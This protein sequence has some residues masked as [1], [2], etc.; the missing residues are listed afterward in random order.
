MASAKLTSEAN[1]RDYL[2]LSESPSFLNIDLGDGT[3]IARDS[4]WGWAART[5]D[6]LVDLN[7]T[8]SSDN[9]SGRIERLLSDVR[10][11]RNSASPVAAIL[12]QTRLPRF[13]A[14]GRPALAGRVP[15]FGGRGSGLEPSSLFS[16]KT[17]EPLRGLFPF[18]D[19]GGS[20][21]VFPD[22]TPVA[23][24]L[25]F[26]RQITVAEQARSVGDNRRSLEGRLIELFAEGGRAV[27]TFPVQAQKS[28]W[29]RWGGTAYLPKDDR[30]RWLEALFEFGWTPRSGA[31]PLSRYVFDET[32]YV[33]L[34]LEGDGMFSR[35]R[36]F[37]FGDE[38]F[39]QRFPT[40]G[41]H[42]FSWASTIDDVMG[43]SVELLEWL[44]SEAWRSKGSTGLPLRTF[45]SYSHDDDRYVERLTKCLRPIERRGAIAKWHDGELFPGT[46]L[47]S[48][49]SKQLDETDVF[50]C[51]L[52][53]SFLASD[54]CVGVEL[55]RA[56]ERARTGDAC[57]VGIV[58]RPCVWETVFP[59]EL[60]VLPTDAKAIAKWSVPD[61]A[62]AC[63]VSELDR[64]FSH[65][66]QS[67][68]PW[69]HM[70]PSP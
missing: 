23:M 38:N 5:Q 13:L 60:L 22:K 14:N 53:D 34:A 63:I 32:G 1:V 35:T 54:Y 41:G 11:L 64:L 26:S 37:H 46:N 36:P 62:W 55:N 19:A 65:L 9:W 59:R 43:S 10:A 12:H 31:Q 17:R 42:P 20:P 15:L 18:I 51:L 48:A 49:I 8:T 21:I 70:R 68:K 45:I 28:I 27:L 66:S 69:P 61:D 40:E 44:L 29:N 25:G 67:P 47:N 39:A 24:R 3:N 50:I 4:D 52:S 57:V 30:Y 16:L 7:R 33:S 56:L 6:I 2:L 58:C